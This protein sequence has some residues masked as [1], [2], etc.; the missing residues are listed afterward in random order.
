MPG[1]ADE[2]HGIAADG[3]EQ[4][5]HGADFYRLIPLLTGVVSARGRRTVT[6]ILWL[7]RGLG[8]KHMTDHH[9]VFSRVE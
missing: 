2:A 8:P 6:S 4:G 5:S 1:L 7:T 9:R 3:A